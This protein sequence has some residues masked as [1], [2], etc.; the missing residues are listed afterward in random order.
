MA[1]YTNMP[2]DVKKMA[3]EAE[4]KIKSGEL[5]ALHRPDQEAGRLGLAEGRRKPSPT[6]ARC[7]A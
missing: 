5:Q 3:E 7:S 1:P 2:D 4:A 6:T